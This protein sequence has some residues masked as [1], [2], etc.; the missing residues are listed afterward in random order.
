[1]SENISDF[2]EDLGPLEVDV[3]FLDK[4]VSTGR[5]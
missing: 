5:C 3:S 4:R 1:M 2:P